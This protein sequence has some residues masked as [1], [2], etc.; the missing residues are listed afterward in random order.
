[1]DFVLRAQEIGRNF[2]KPDGS[3]LPILSGIDLDL[4]AGEVVCLLGASGCGKTTLLRILAG[5][6]KNFV[7]RIESRVI[8]PGISLGYLSQSDLLLPWR[9][10]LDNVAL[11][12]ELT[13]HSPSKARQAASDVLAQVGLAAFVEHYPAQLSGGMKQRVLLARMLALK[14]KLLLLDEPMSSLDVLARCELAN[15]I[16]SYTQ[17]QNAATLVV[18]HSVEEACFLADRILIITPSPAHIGKEIHM[19]D[20]GNTGALERSKA[21]DSVMCELRRVLGNAA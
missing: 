2:R 18:T 17:T 16:K 15:I 6:D 19:T 3:V 13:G 20:V 9:T 4:A 11:G 7:G 21:L 10:A 1:M 12:L 5:L 8:R 14:P